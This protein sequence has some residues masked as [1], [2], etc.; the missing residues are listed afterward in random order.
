MTAY[1]RS[2]LGNSLPSEIK[3][4]PFPHLVIKN[5]LPDDLYQTLCD[6]FPEEEILKKASGENKRFDLHVCESQGR[7]S[8]TWQSFINTHT[9]LAFW[10]DVVRIFGDV[11]RFVYPQ[12]EVN[13]GRMKEWYT[14]RRGIDRGTINL[15]CQPG[16]NTPQTTFGSVRGPHLDNPVELFAAMLYMGEG[17]G[18]LELYR[19]IRNP[20]YHGKLELDPDCVEKVDEVKYEPNTLVAFINTITSIHGVSPRQPTDKCRRLCNFAGEVNFQLFKTGWGK[21]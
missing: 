1:V 6:E 3:L 5:C 12:L 18:D 9:S 8:P 21:Y 20:V 7:V 15:E 16:V 17:E 13:L 10:L 19:P 11:T 14:A 2:I 4:Y